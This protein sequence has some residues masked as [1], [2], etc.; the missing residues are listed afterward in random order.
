MAKGI[1]QCF[2][3]IEINKQQR[4]QSVVA[5]G[6]YQRELQPVQQQSAVRQTCQCIKKCQAVYLGLGRLALRNVSHKSQY[7][8]D[9]AVVNDFPRN[10]DLADIAIPVHPAR[11]VVHHTA[12]GLQRAQPLEPHLAL[13][14]EAHL[15]RSLAQQLGTGP[16]EVTL[17]FLVGLNESPFRQR[18]NRGCH[19]TGLKCGSKL[20]LR[21]PQVQLHQFTGVNVLG[22]TGHP[23]HGTLVI[24]LKSRFLQNPVQPPMHPDL[25]LSLKDRLS[26]CRVTP[27]G[28]DGL[29]LVD[30]Y[31]VEERITAQRSAIR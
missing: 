4:P 28:K 30:R 12:P 29:T 14:P 9:A 2:E 7:A 3:V 13:R 15:Q 17:V 26:P 11:L 10:A 18:R 23:E 24:P 19:R 21:L 6:R 27:E 16:T 5:L 20:L 1:V 31:Q 8:R 25:V 22:G